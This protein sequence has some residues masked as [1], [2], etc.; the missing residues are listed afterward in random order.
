M[1][2]Q[3]MSLFRVPLIAIDPRDSSHVTLP[4]DALV[5]TGS[6]LSWLPA[7]L[8]ADAGIASIR[9]RNFQTAT[10]QV[11]ARD[12]G[13]A[14]LRTPGFET[15]DEVVFGEPGDLNILGVHTIEGFG[16]VVDPVSRRLIATT[17]IVAA[18][19]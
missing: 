9:K 13:Y 12:T 1:S 11:I 15:I 7:K 4:I 14:I 19:A 5:D 3:A 2:T 18:A 8:L 10:G 6:E 17:M 16:A